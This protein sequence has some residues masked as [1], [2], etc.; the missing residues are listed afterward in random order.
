MRKNQLAA[1]KRFDFEGLAWPAPRVSRTVIDFDMWSGFINLAP[2]FLL[3][4]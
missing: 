3:E 1:I 2:P 4:N